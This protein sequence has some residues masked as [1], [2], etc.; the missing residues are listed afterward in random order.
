MLHVLQS[1]QQFLNIW[2]SLHF[3]RKSGSYKVSND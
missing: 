2:Q 3:Y 1:F